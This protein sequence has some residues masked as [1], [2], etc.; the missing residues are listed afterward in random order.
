[1][2]DVAGDSRF[3]EAQQSVI[4]EGATRIE[5]SPVNI[6]TVAICLVLVIMT[7]EINF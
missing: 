4:T 1:M 2:A 3:S 6:H 5:F 7:K